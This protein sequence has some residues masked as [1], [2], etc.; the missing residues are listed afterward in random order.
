MR[1]LTYALT[2][3]FTLSFI[4]ACSLNHKENNLEE[5]S[6]RAAGYDRNNAFFQTNSTDPTNPIHDLE[7]RVDQVPGVSNVS[8]LF[9][10]TDNLIVAFSADNTP[11]IEVTEARVR[12]ELQGEAKHYIVYLVTQEHPDLLARVRETRSQQRQGN[13]IR[14]EDMLS[15]MQGIWKDIVPFNFLSKS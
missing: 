12:Q 6:Y 13:S 5:M 9:Y 7:R 11:S 4:T 3:M 14:D 2:L 10:P 15:V 1:K 8:V